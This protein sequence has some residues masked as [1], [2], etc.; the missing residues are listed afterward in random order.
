MFFMM[1]ILRFF[2]KTLQAV[3]K[4]GNGGDDDDD[5][6]NH[7][8]ENCIDNTCDDL[9]RQLLKLSLSSMFFLVLNHAKFT[10]KAL[11]YSTEK[12]TFGIYSCFPVNKTN[13]GLDDWR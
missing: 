10:E 13:I 11:I 1:D 2:I 9:T 6:Y 5:D 7:D 4:D 12:D 3:D 8:S